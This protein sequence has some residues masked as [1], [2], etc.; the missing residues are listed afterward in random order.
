[1][2][3]AVQVVS[4]IDEVDP[5]AWGELVDGQ[6]WTGR[7]WHRFGEAV[8]DDERSAYL[9]LWDGGKLVGRATFWLR[10]KESLPITSRVARALTERLLW[11]RP[12][13]LCQSP[14][15]S[16]S[17]LT[18]PSEG[19]SKALAILIQAAQEQA[20][21]KGASFVAAPY[22]GRDETAWA[23]WPESFAAVR[24]PDPGMQLRIRWS[25]FD[26]YVAGLPKSVRKDYR[27]HRNRAADEGIC[28]TRR[29]ITTDRP[30][31]LVDEALALIRNVERAHNSAPNPRARA[32][33][34]NAARVESTW[35]EARRGERLV[36]CGLVLGEGPVRALGLLGLDY[37]VRYVY[38]QLLYAA[39][40]SAI[41]EGVEV[42]RGGGGAYDI[43]GRLGFELEG[44]NHV[45][46][47]GNGP[48]FQTMG[49]WLARAEAQPLAGERD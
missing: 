3:Y 15:A 13:F 37:G 40:R 23:G 34:E 26:E 12:L 16:A 27:R 42:L 4:S 5:A 17:G 33:L 30:I 10:R 18:L 48:L 49:R 25:D 47:A 7:R 11:R 9:L 8:L 21:K 32:V 44:N 46:V 38:F 1:M 45:M 31:V 22:L 39:I 36:G 28:I 14:L 43:K 29:Q 20:R 35:L 6:P 24:V 2:G 19:R 41:E